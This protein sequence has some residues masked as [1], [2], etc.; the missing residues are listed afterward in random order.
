MW[1]WF[2]GGAAAKK[3]AP[4]KAILGLRS[5][6]EMLNKREKHLETQIDE[7]DNLARKY[8]STNKSAA[9][10]ALRRKKQFEQTLEQTRGQIMTLESQ[11]YSIEAAN[12]NKETLDAMK[13]ASAAMKQIHGGLTIDK[14]DQTMEE[15]REQHAIGEE[16]SEAITQSIGQNAVDDAELED[17]LDELMQEELDNKMMKTG[18]VPA[19]K[20]GALP[21]APEDVKAGKARVEEDDEEEELKRLQAEMAM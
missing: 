10:N 21:A 6:L 4:K 14:V 2:G 13:N 12:I 17:E 7:Q 20:I 16:I 18:T 11:I 9:K 8:V 3:D 19:D 15:L 5:Q 1:N